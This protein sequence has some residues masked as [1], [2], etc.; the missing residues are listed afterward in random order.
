MKGTF[1]SK[2]LEWNIETDKESWSQGESI[3]GV[4][5]VKNHS[6]DE[7]D[8]TE[9][10][11]GLAHADIKKVHARSEGAMKFEQ[12]E[13]FSQ[14][15]LAAQETLELNFCLNLPPNSPVT[16]KK[17]SF[18]LTYGKNHTE[19]HLMLK[20]EPRALFVKVIGLLDTFQRFKVKEIK[21]AKSGVE[22]KLLPP[23]SRDLAN[24]E[25]LNLTFSMQG[26]MLQMEYDFQVR[27]LDTA[28]ITTKVNKEGVKIQKQLTPKEYSLGKDMINQDA[29]LKSLEAAIGEVK[30]KSVF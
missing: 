24:L 18:Y 28:S 20:I 22:Y 2:P 25:S 21:S 17:A 16:D 30:L 26:E 6:S 29:L 4:L 14:K 10:G 15:T 1:F 5:R 9:A 23:T 11:V 12:K 13:N 19:N 3:K 27:K 7:I 8:L